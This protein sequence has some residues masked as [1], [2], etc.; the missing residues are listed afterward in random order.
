MFANN[1]WPWIGFTAFVLAMLALDLAVFHRKVH[2]VSL[3]EASIWSGVW[4][5]LALL[6]NAGL[7]LL[8]GPMPALQFFTGYLIE[9]SLSVDNIFVFTLLFTYFKV[10]AAYQH[11]VLFWGILGA[12]LMRGML[13]AV[14]VVLLEEVHWI[15]YLFGAFLIFTGVRMGL[16]RETEVHPDKNP[17]IRFVRRLI[18]ITAD[19]A[20]ERF[21]VRQAGRLLA[22]PLF[23]VLLAIESADLVFAVDS[24]PAIFGVTQDPFI[25]YTSNVFAILGLRS[26]Y[27]V[28]ANIIDKFYYLKPGLAVILTYVGV[29]M[30]LADIYPISPLTSLAIIVG[31]LTIA[32]IASVIRA[33][34]EEVT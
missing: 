27:F 13:I 9:K 17:F 22:T 8:R 30:L 29:K 2:T 24:I 33:R 34:R 7:Y 32:I 15:I 26:L 28:F 16:K 4:I 12:L 1:L 20:G 31:V 10:P 19:Y 25:V 23:L 3:K 6:F 21:F 18:P 14:G 5:A 11:R